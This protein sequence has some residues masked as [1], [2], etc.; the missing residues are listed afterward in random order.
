MGLTD[1]FIVSVFRE[2][3]WTVLLVS[4]P[5]LGAGLVVGLIISIFQATT[6]I[7]EQTMAFIPK[8]VTIFGVLVIFFP[9]MMRVINDFAAKIFGNLNQ[10]T[11][12]KLV[13]VWLGGG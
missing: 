5:M 13:A 3:L 12:I 7:Q 9:W 8:I 10:F 1:T 2:A 6:Q 11:F 4:A